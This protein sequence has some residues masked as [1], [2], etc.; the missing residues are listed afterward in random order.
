MQ[1]V[2]RKE[3]STM[4]L[5]YS[6]YFCVNFAHATLVHCAYLALYGGKLEPL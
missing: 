3:G 1:K 2:N 4:Y 6:M 5:A